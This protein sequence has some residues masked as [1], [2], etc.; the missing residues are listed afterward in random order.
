[1]TA[2]RRFCFAALLALSACAPQGQPQTQTA[3]AATARPPQ[4]QPA[5]FTPLAD[6]PLKDA[7]L[8]AADYLARQQL[9]NGELS[10]QVNFLNGEREYTPLHIRLMEGVG[11]LYTA[12]RISGQ[13]SY[14]NSGD[15]A[16]RRYMPLLVTDSNQFT[17]TCFYADGN[18]LLGGAAIMVDVIYKRWQ[19]ADSVTLDDKNLLDVALQLGYF[20]LSMRKPNGGFYHALDPHIGG[21]AD[22]AYFSPAFMGMSLAALLDL[23]EMT[24]DES[25]LRQ[26]REANAYQITQPATEDAWQGYALRNFARAGGLSPAEI[27]YA[28]E[29]AQTII[30]GEVRSLNPQ[31]SSV[32]SAAKI[33]AL[34]MLAQAL[35]LAGQEHL[36]LDAEIRAFITFV[37]ARQLPNHNC[38]WT[39]APQTIENFN[40]GVF[41]SCEDSTLR[42]DGAAHFINGLADY[43]E[44]R[45]M[46]K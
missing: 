44:Y 38:G 23:S 30:S 35:A 7:A 13:A 46:I 21:G 18:C 17:G 8:A 33:E 22:P 20:I 40:G 16:L 28:H 41:N 29:A 15:L 25:W 12:C 26:A 34:S 32:S 14:C 19:A 1:M 3:R 9:P 39:L 45:S 5:L 37:Q 31:N 24:G 6:D 10:Y 2:W 36:W 27:S 11:A 4:I 43:L 42:V